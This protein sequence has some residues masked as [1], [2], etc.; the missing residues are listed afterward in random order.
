MVLYDTL[1][2][3]CLSAWKVICLKRYENGI[4]MRLQIIKIK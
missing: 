3:I 2:I 4:R 1:K